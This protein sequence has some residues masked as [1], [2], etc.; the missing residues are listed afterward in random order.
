MDWVTVTTRNTNCQDFK[1][2]YT[3]LGFSQISE[4]ENN[5]LQT[6]LESLRILVDRYREEQDYLKDI[7]FFSRN[8]LHLGRTLDCLKLIITKTLTGR[9]RIKELA[10]ERGKVFNY[11]VPSVRF[12]VIEGKDAEIYL[13]YGNGKGKENI[14]TIANIDSFLIKL[15]FIEYTVYDQL[16]QL[17]K[18][19][20]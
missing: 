7:N 1:F 19:Y 9:F 12:R 18:G 4:E 20:I 2:T 17:N 16:R 14:S 15:Y 3:F 11:D 5:R 8:Q 10:A 13:D 6:M